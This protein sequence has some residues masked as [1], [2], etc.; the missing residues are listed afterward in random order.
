M[1]LLYPYYMRYHYAVPAVDRYYAFAALGMLLA[2]VWAPAVAWGVA[3]AVRGRFRSLTP[4][5]ACIAVPLAPLPLALDT[6]RRPRTD[7]VPTPEYI[8]EW[9]PPSGPV[10]LAVRT[11]ETADFWWLGCVLFF[12]AGVAWTRGQRR[13]VFGSLVAL[14]CYGGSHGAVTT[15]LLHG[16]VVRPLFAAPA[17]AVLFA[18]GAKLAATDGEPADDP[19]EQPRPSPAE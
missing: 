10:E 14:V 4:P 2:F 16:L 6:F 17:G 7:V 3:T 1:L 12:V 19:A 5:L 8:T 13:W 11:F 18:V 9:T 15:T